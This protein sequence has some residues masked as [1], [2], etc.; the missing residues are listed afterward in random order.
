MDAL[1]I[2]FMGSGELACPALEALLA[3]PDEV[4]AVV[5]QPERPKGRRLEIAACPAKAFADA[6]GVPVLTPGQ[7]GAEGS[8]EAIR[9]LAPDLIVVAAYG[10]YI[11]P[12]ILEVPR[13]GAINIH[14]SLLPRYRGASPIQAA[15]ANGDETTGVTILHVA[16]KL[17]AG[18]II[19]QQEAPI[20][21][22]DTAATLLPR[23]AGL[24]ARLLREAV[25]RLRAG[26]APRIPQDDARAVYAG[27][28]TKADGRI[29]WTRPAGEI[30][31]QIRAFT[32][33]PG[34]CCEAP[35]GSG[36]LLGIREARVEPGGGA[37]GTLLETGA[38]G[39]LIATG[40]DALRLLTVHPPGGRPM[41][42][43]AF[44]HGHPFAP[45]DSMG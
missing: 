15:I 28:L 2:L 21:P 32:P 44:L 20:R 10:Q 35:T 22:D 31:N 1:R 12:A 14:P 39:P 19:L 34:C 3:G 8:V 41:S 11:K 6:R 43:A 24:G 23:L 30:L 45:G 27:K 38:D 7:V 26:D 33:W 13:L 5:S 40:R 16:Q 9:E 17:D 37:P 36:I 25:D 18:D 29:D 4:V 42:G